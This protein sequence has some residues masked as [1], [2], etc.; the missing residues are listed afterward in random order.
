M[1]AEDYDPTPQHQWQ[2]T[3]PPEV[4]ATGTDEEWNP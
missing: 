2:V 1:S 4:Y 3:T